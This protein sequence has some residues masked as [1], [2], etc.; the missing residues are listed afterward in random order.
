M[1]ANERSVSD[2]LQ[3]IIQNI[4]EIVRSEVRLAKAELR[5]EAAKAKS[6]SL[7]IA[8]GAVVAI[9]AV[10]F[11]LLTVVY[12]LSLVMPNWAAALIVGILL[13]IAAGVTLASG[14]K[15][16]KRVHPTPQRTVETL[17]ENVEWAKQ[18]SK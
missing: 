3:N 13:A 2:V 12:A 16:F 4:Q 7:A 14:L 11:L 10:L 17:K 9:Y 18:Q 15:Q 1:A 8:I 5:D 6:A